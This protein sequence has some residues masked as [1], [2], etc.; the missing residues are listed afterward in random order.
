MKRKLIRLKYY[1]TRLVKN[2]LKSSI[3]I[4]NKTFHNFPDPIPTLLDLLTFLCHTPL[5]LSTLKGY[6]WCGKVRNQKK[7]RRY[8]KRTSAILIPIRFVL[9]KPKFKYPN[10]A[11][12]EYMTNS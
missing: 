6:R 9:I 2:S 10:L 3:I 4:L 5:I 1:I 11:E 8:F 12:L 7:S